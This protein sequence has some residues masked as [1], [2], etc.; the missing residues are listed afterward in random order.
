MGYIKNRAK[1]FYNHSRNL[2]CILVI[3]Y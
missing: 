3:I 2:I 1:F